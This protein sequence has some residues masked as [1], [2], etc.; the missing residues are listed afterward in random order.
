MPLCSR[1]LSKASLSSPSTGLTLCSPCFQNLRFKS[2]QCSQGTG[3]FPHGQTACNKGLPAMPQQL[4]NPK[5]CGA[6]PLREVHDER[7]YNHK[8]CQ[9]ETPLQGE[10]ASKNQLEGLRGSASPPRSPRHFLSQFTPTGARDSGHPRANCGNFSVCL[11][12][13]PDNMKTEV[14]PA[15]RN[16]CNTHAAS[17]LRTRHYAFRHPIRQLCQGKG[18]TWQNHACRSE[19]LC[20]LGGRTS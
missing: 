19:I 12:R 18:W 11:P 15:S 16:S 17:Q 20:Q 10:K 14:E 13:R 3:K 7:P 9:T 4:Q 1:A 5:A 2:L 8:G 6:P